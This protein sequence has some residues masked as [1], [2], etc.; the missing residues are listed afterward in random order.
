VTP[1]GIG[2]VVLLGTFIGLMVNYRFNL[3]YVD[4]YFVIGAVHG[5]MASLISWAAVSA[6]DFFFA[7]RAGR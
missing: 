3:S 7:S 1:A 6:Y 5:V 4:F 2:L